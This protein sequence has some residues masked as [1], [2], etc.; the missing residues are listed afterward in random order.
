[1]TETWDPREVAAL[2]TELADREEFAGANPFQVRA[3]R[4]AARLLAAGAIDLGAPESFAKTPG[5]GPK[6]AEKLRALIATGTIPRLERL[7]QEQPEELQA[8]LALPGIGPKTLRRLVAA[9]LERVA[10]LE[11]RITAGDPPAVLSRRQL[12]SLERV[13]ALRRQ[14]MPL[15]LLMAFS[16]TL[17]A[18]LDQPAAPAGGLARLDPV[19]AD[20]LWVAVDTAQNRRLAASLP[21]TL[22]NG[23]IVPAEALRLVP[24]ERFGVALLNAVGPSAFV[25]EVA[26]R[27]A[28]AGL[29]LTA[30]RLLLREEEVPTPDEG[31]LFARAGMEPVP[32]HLRGLAPAERRVRLGPVLGDLHTHSNWSDGAADIRTMAQAAKALGYRYLAI[33]D[34]SAG[35]A[36]PHGLGV[37]GFAAQRAELKAVAAELGPD[38]TLLQGAEVN[39]GPDGSLDLPDG[40]LAEL[41]VVVASLHSDLD[42]G[43]EAVT[44]RLL[45]AVTHPLVTILGHPM[46]RKLGLR[47]PV[48]ADWP[49]VLKAAADHGVAVELNASPRRLDL[50]PALLAEG[51]KVGPLLVAVDTDAHAP[52]EL[53]GMALGLLLAEKAGVS[54]SELL[55]LA[56]AE[57]VRRQGRG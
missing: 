25:A 7:R 50:D 31:T 36:V 21:A 12:A 5:I 33:T 19:V 30:D 8:L 29:T 32:P 26:A 15:P 1:V 4:E 3:Y 22:P 20:P 41:D 6:I 9:G 24:E 34:H 46:A 49:R 39:I 14:G 10:E 40:L 56:P 55:N 2:F 47:A 27:L 18:A 37:E 53:E 11:A 52:T 16:R 13:F 44:E 23:Q 45:R 43:T 57:A 48:P 51:R 28:A 38:F 35:L 54:P 42:D 17:L